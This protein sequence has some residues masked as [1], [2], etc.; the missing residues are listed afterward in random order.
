MLAS[1]LVTTTAIS[2]ASAC[3]GKVTGGGQCVTEER[4]EI[5]SASF[6]FN[7]MW[8]GKSI[9]QGELNYVDH[10]TGMHVHIH[11]LD[12]LEVWETLEGNKPMPLRKAIFGDHAPSMVRKVSGLMCTLR[13]TEN[14]AKR[15]NSKYMS[16]MA[17]PNLLLMMQQ[18]TMAVA[19]M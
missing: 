16:T 2:T 19:A 18:Y 3:T 1:L 12:Y 7:A 13:T 17:E 4:K 9:L 6:G 14:Q 5:P 15:T 10:T 8:T 11:E